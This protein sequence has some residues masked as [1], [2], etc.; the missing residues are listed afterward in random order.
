M[1]YPSVW[2]TSDTVGVWKPR[3]LTLGI[4][5]PGDCPPKRKIHVSVLPPVP[6]IP[7]G[8]NRPVTGC[9]TFV[10]C[11]PVCTCRPRAFYSW[12]PRQAIGLSAETSP[13]FLS[14]ANWN[15][16][17]V[18]FPTLHPGVPTVPSTKPRN[19]SVSTNLAT[20][21]FVDSRH[22]RAHSSRLVNQPDF[23]ISTLLTNSPP[24][25][26]KSFTSPCAVGT[27][28]F[29]YTYQSTSIHCQGCRRGFNYPCFGCLPVL[30]P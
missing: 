21:A 5:S 24:H 3:T 2:D 9:R 7:E 23:P 14:C 28:W 13:N 10:P 4:T 30:S 22:V 20:T 6:T 8:I 15:N 27:S 18:M 17:R 26:R 11:Y 12:K 16:I 19:F 29:S 1:G 25:S